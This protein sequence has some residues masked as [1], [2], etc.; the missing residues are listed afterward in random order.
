MTA[1]ATNRILAYRRLL[2]IAGLVFALDQASKAW[3]EARLPYGTYGPG[4]I[5]VVRGFLY[6]VHVGNTG[7][8]WSLFRGSSVPLAVLAAATLAAIVLW[9][10]ALGLAEPAV[11]TCF[12]LLCGGI[13]GNLADRLR[14]GHVVDFIDVHFG[15]WAYP[16]FNVADSGICIGVALYLLHS[17]RPRGAS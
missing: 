9:R 6:L 11:Q 4:S 5:R 2:F 13:A 7:A 3:I 17:L 1:G 14:L 8:A 16:T 12:G 15:A 10:R